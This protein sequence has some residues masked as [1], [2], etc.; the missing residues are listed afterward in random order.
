MG[1]FLLLKAAAGQALGQDS[2]G[3]STLTM[4]LSKNTFT[5]TEAHGFEGIVRKAL[6]WGTGII[7]AILFIRKIKSMNK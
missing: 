4:Q 3:G 6:T 5:S 1:R 7:I 2:G